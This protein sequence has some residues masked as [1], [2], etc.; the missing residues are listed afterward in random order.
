LTET[1]L[2]D[3]TRALDIFEDVLADQPDYRPALQAVSR[4]V[5]GP[6]QGPRAV[7]IL[8][9]IF[10]ESGDL[11]ALVGVLEAKARQSADAL[12][13]AEVWREVG[14]LH[15]G[16]GAATQAF[17]A[18]AKALVAQPAD[19]AA[20]AEVD[21]WASA[22]GCWEAYNAAFEEAAA[23][24][25][26]S[27]VRGA[28]LRSVAQTQD[29]EL[30]DPRAAIDTYRRM[31]AADPDAEG[32]LDDLEGLQVMVGD[33][34][35]LAWLYEE[36][37]ERA[38]DSEARAQLLDRLGGLWE[39]QLSNPERAVAYYQ[40]AT[41]ENPED[42]AAYAALDRL[43][44]SANDAKRLA[45]VLERRLEIEWE[46][47]VRVEV[48]MRLA[49]LYE[50]QLGRPEAACD[51]LRAVV[52]AEPAHRGAL[53]GLSRLCERQGQ[54]Q[55]LVEVLRRR[56]DISA[57]DSERVALTHQLGNI[58]ERELDDEL[59]AIAVYGQA[60]RVDPS[61][62]PSVQSL[63][64]ITK[65]ADFREDAA[66]VVEPY[67]RMQ[68][69][70][71][72]LAT[73]LQLR[74]DAMI[75][76]DQKAEQLVALAEVHEQGRKDPN[77]ALD[78]LLQSIGERP[79]DEVLDRAEAI[80][81]GLRRWSDLVEV[82]LAE[83]GASLD[84]ERGVALYQRA[85]R[86][87]EEDLKDLSRAIDAHERALSLS[88]DQTSILQGL[89]RLLLA[90]EQWDRLHEV[91]SRR[92]DLQ[93]ADR[94]TLFL[95][96]GRLRADHLGDFEGALQAYQ[97]ALHEEPGRDDV[98][99][100]VRD[101]THKP[102][103]SVGA[104]DLLEEHYRG[105]GNLEEVVRLY[106]R[107]VELASTDAERVALLTEAAAIWEKDMGRP[108]QALV[109]LRKAVRI[110]PRD[111]HLV[112]SLERLADR[113]GRW[114]DLD[115][116]VED[117]AAH[118]DLDRR[119]LYELR[120]RSAAW[121]RDRL[122]DLARAERALAEAI[123]LDPEPIE[124]HAERVALIRSQGRDADLVGALRAWSE[125]EPSTETRIALLREAA[126]VA[127]DKLSDLALAADCYE[128]LL[129]FERNDADALQALTDI[130]GKQ[131]RWNEVVGLLEQKLHLVTS[132]E[133][134]SVA[135][136]VGQVYRDYLDDP[137]AA[138]RAYESALELDGSDALAMDALEGLYRDNDR[139]EALRGLLERRTALASEA[140]RTEVQLRL[141]QL[142]EHS[143]R[144]HAGAIAM[145]RQVLKTDPDNDIAN[146]DL[147][148]L[149][150]A[151]G[152]WHDLVA[153]LSFRADR[154]SDEARRALLERIASVHETKLGDAD[155]A[156]A[157]HGR[158]DS[159]L[160][161]NEHSLRAMAR[162][163]ERKGK[164][165]EMAD[166]L[167]RLAAHLTGQD[168]IDLLHRAA[169]VWQ[170][171][172][173]DVEQAGRVLRKAYE[174]FPHDGATRE[175]IKEHYA[176]RGDYGALVQVL[177]AE[178]Q[179]VAS[180]DERVALLRTLSN[181]YRDRLGDPKMA[182]SYL[183]RAVELDSSDRGALIPL[184]DLYV[185]AGRQKDAVPILQRIIES[186]G[187][188]RT[189]ELAL[190]YHRLGQALEAMGDVPAALEAYDAAFKIDLTNVGILR[191]LGKLTHANGD[192]D[193]AQKSFRAL[194]LQ[195][196]EPDSG[197]R[198]ADVYYYLGDI[199]VKQDDRH[200]AI[201]MLERALAEDAGHEQAS[202]LLTQLKG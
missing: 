180:D 115:G 75:D 122:G 179:G 170:Q 106:D 132:A 59:S 86:I 17:S 96:Q 24:A 178:L 53:E 105:A 94:A 120:L 156:I 153:L 50:A 160:G 191:D 83:A 183:E 197:I 5:E 20:R 129:A 165:A 66:A 25:S 71:S 138:I 93:D 65:L 11:G 200:K 47:E 131:S 111:R 41:G 36:K 147:E 126:D 176:V 139:L 130:R 148:R 112:D 76:P 146:A 198:K 90:T 87:C 102:Q 195:K 142:Y 85:A 73:L 84:P 31:L 2:G 12:D 192:L 95:R 28:L 135:R 104:L 187:R 78:A 167:E 27:A 110:D 157:V 79:D 34:H 10:R 48:G 3:P 39:E 21:R 123:Q 193:R 51:A 173:G 26:D 149:F 155:A 8:E 108:E 60:L 163:C 57:H 6:E 77:A 32:V 62:E 99:A 1:K 124:A 116:L 9:P 150:E 117:I 127:R 69:R 55:D 19:E 64:R 201:T 141:A 91:V 46:P 38:H 44:V 172:G 101:L 16:R 143:F 15:E 140:D 37:L 177:D 169:D 63:L 174:R 137:R 119:E 199:A 159:E 186:F 52:E 33:W 168:S 181:V 194:L 92:L 81:A 158:I 30:G 97:M 22:L 175:R 54:W 40:Q 82:V 184:C 56:A 189:K 88:G 4:F 109:V 45:D 98:L 151:T 166:A 118:G 185:A 13:Q 145:F 74:A 188:Q 61:H 154:E 29:R 114:A 164:W 58:L 190:H 70:W 128:A 67:L 144:D 113:T 161:A 152:A 68:E 72:D 100:A 182:A 89:D 42:A 171:R 14:R 136:A 7:Q 23:A 162:L 196:L 121:Y 103:V 134:A 49:E 43:F 18:W 202:A 80:A 125:A 107:R 35:G 133:R